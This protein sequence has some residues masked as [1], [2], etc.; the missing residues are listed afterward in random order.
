METVSA[1]SVCQRSVATRG[2]RYVKFLGDGDSKAFFAVSER[3][4]YGEK[5]VEK[6]E[7]IGHVQKRMGYR[8]RKLKQQLGGNLLSDGKPIKGP[9]RLTDKIIDE[10]QSYYGNAIRANVNSL[11]NMKRAVWATFFH[12]LS[13]DVE[14]RHQLCPPPPDTWCK[15]RLAQAENKPYF[16]KHSI[17]PAVM[18][19]IKPT[20]QA[21]SKPELLKKCL[22]GKTQNVNESFNNVIWSRIPKNTFVGRNTLE[23]GVYDSLLTF[24]D[25]NI[26]RLK[27]FKELQFTDYGA[28]TV[29]AL[30]NADAERLRKAE[31][32]AKEMTKE[33]RIQKRRKRLL[34]DE[35]K[36]KYYSPG[37]F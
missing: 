14:P 26:G 22:H 19:A 11:D 2:V 3:K 9:G 29:A 35:D 12:R 17:P 6:L 34:L 10:L 20:F 30:R 8:L 28:N 5:E 16:H 32:A 15:Y 18:E 24:N 13:T 4:P 21:L 36:Q 27:V 25:G 37:A 31:Q 1:V 33:S 7:C 23:L